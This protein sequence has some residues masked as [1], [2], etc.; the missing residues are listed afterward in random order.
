MLC[1]SASAVSILSLQL[2]AVQVDVPCLLAVLTFV[3]QF[4]IYQ[5]QSKVDP[6][7]VPE[8]VSLPAGEQDF[9]VFLPGQEGSVPTTTHYSGY[10]APPPPILTQFLRFMVG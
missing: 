6:S 9:R 2:L 5:R 1:P 8:S 4:E 7:A 10:T 3:C